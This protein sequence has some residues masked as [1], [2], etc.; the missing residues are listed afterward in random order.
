MNSFED[1]AKQRDKLREDIQQ[2]DG[3]R[4]ANDEEPNMLNTATEL[5]VKKGHKD[6]IIKF[7]R[8]LGDE[9]INRE[10][11]DIDGGLG[12]VRKSNSKDTAMG[13]DEVVP[14]PVDHENPGLE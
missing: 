14:S 8:G 2:D 10:L 12:N 4:I 1:Y 11:D 9:E 6:A 7:L 3:P 5:G 13:Q